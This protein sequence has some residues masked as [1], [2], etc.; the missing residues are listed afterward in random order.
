VAGGRRRGAEHHTDPAT[1]LLEHGRIE[2]AVPDPV[3][4][5][6]ERARDRWIESIE[7]AHPVT[8]VVGVGTAV[9]R[10]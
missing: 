2:A 1:A 6:G 8:S 4:E 3:D 10:K 9:R 7:G 5:V